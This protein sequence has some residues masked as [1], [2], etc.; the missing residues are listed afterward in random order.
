MTAASLHPGLTDG[1]TEIRLYGVLGKKF[2][3]VH[4]LAVAS[5]R[6]AAQALAV[7]LPG[8][9]AHLLAHS[10]PG[11]RIFIGRPGGE[12]R[13]ENQLDAPLS[14]RERI[15]IVPVVAG[16]KSGLASIVLGAA[17]LIFAPYAA[18]FLFGTGTALGTSA[19]LAIANFGGQV[20]ASLILG[21]IV[22]LV[23]PQR[24]GGSEPRPENEPSYNFGG[25]INTTQQG[26]PV[27]LVY[28]RVVTGGAV[29][30][31]GILTEEIAPATAA[32]SLPVQP[33]PA[34]QPLNPYDASQ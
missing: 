2:G 19:A 9:G 21:G 27:P 5:V 13:N 17:L 14:T 23:S 8:F 20:A 34:E 6:E 15:C 18:G 31:A 4:R 3:R 24:R 32:G 1:L 26:L 7:V 25:A 29:I 12:V 16:A 28:G 30:S 11:Y 22:Q 10:A 33:L